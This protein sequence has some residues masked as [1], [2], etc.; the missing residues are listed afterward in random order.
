MT[1]HICVQIPQWTLMAMQIPQWMFMAIA[2]LANNLGEI[3]A[4]RQGVN[5]SIS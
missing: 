4:E 2:M 5:T 3:S 1:G